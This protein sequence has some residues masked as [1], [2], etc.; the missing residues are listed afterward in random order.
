MSKL[1]L[2]MIRLA[3]CVV[4]EINE[5]GSRRGFGKGEAGAVYIGANTH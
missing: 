1:G 5:C 4:L 2:P 3:F